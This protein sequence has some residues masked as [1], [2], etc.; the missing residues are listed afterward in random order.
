M[1][2]NYNYFLKA[3]LSSFIGEWVAVC[4]NKIVAHGSNIQKVYDKAVKE[5]P[6]KRPLLAKVPEKETM[7]F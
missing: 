1:A 4:G 5:C 3:D 7:I 6:N 2:D